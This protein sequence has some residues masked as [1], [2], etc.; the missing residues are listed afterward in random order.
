MNEK[1]RGAKSNPSN[2]EKG[3]E[4]ETEK[5]KETVM[6]YEWIIVVNDKKTK[7]PFIRSLASMFLKCDC[8]YLGR[9]LSGYHI[10][11]GQYQLALTNM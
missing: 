4:K 9:E 5:I 7:W 8:I 3:T 1:K 10:F 6:W 2:W 11:T